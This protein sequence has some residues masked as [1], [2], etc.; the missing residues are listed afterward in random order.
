MGKVLTCA[1]G[2]KCEPLRN[3]S[4]LEVMKKSSCCWWNRLVPDL[5]CRSELTE[6]TIAHRLVIQHMPALNI[7]TFWRQLLVHIYF[8]D[9]HLSTVQSS[10]WLCLKL[11]A[12]VWNNLGSC[13]QFTPYVFILTLPLTFGRITGFLLKIFSQFVKFCLCSCNTQLHIPAGKLIP[14]LH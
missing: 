1:S 3:V 12:H 13:K 7:I 2:Q 9:C 10:K 5:I 8:W 11:W 14:L 6:M 4:V